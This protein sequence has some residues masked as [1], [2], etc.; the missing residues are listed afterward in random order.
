MEFLRL[1]EIYVLCDT[2]LLFKL[3]IYMKSMMSDFCFLYNKVY[4]EMIRIR[5]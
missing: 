4:N 5:M 1:S 2:L 3:G